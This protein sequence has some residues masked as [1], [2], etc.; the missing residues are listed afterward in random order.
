MQDSSDDSNTLTSFKASIRHN[1]ESK[2]TPHLLHKVAVFL[3]PRQK[4]MR[5]LSPQDRQNVLE[6]VDE[7]LEDLPLRAHQPEPAPIQEP[8]SK[9]R[10]YAIDDFDDIPAEEQVVSELD[11]YKNIAVKVEELNLPILDWWK[12]HAGQFPALSKLARNVLCIMAS[13]SPSERNFSIAG[14]VVSARRSCLKPSSINNI[15]FL[16]SAKRQDK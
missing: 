3:N 13:S 6:Y 8:P 4:S 16:N 2:F 12:A 15:L 10:K 14:I 5:V 11:E 9:R 7:Q 1:L